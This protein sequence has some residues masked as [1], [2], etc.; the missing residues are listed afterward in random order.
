MFTHFM[1][2]ATVAVGLTV[3]IFVDFATLMLVFGVCESQTVHLLDNTQLKTLQ[4][5]I[6]CSKYEDHIVLLKSSHEVYGIM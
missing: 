2:S 6:A 3:T 1:L 4:L 5:L